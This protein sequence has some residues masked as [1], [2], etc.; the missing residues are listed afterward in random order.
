M[1]TRNSWLSYLAGIVILGL[2]APVSAQEHRWEIS[3]EAGYLFGG[4]IVSD[5]DASGRKVTGGLENAGVYGLR[6]AYV[7][8][9]DAEIELQASRTDARFSLTQSSGVEQS[10]FRTDYLIGSGVYRFRVG[11]AENSIARVSLGAGA[12]RLETGNAPRSTRFTGAIGAG[13]VRYLYPR[14]G[15]RLDGRVFASR[16]AGLNLGSSCRIFVSGPPEDDSRPCDQRSWLINA[17]VTAGL[18]FGF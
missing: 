15:F 16:L 17:D 6:M 5:H 9:S 14:L 2:S 8:S 10:A 18:T 13:F 1:R 11:D 3:P 4:S 7:A 12:A